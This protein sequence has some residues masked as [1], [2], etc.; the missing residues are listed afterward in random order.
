MGTEF[1]IAVGTTVGTALGV[2]VGTAEGGLTIGAPV[3]GASL[4]SREGYPAPTIIGSKARAVTGTAPNRSVALVVVIAAA[5]AFASRPF[6]KELTH[7]FV[8]V[9]ASD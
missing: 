2:A 9:V 7:L 5:K 8:R 4:G 6:G 3:T 1:G